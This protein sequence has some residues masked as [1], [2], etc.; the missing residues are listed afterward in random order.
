M[1]NYEFTRY[2][3]YGHTSDPFPF[4]IP[5]TNFRQEDYFVAI[6]LLVIH[7]MVEASIIAMRV[8]IK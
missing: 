3:G 6:L 2:Y 5:T 8:I 7:C 4:Q 1:N